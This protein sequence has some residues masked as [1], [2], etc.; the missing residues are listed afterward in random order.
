M[1]K[2]G[3]GRRARERVCGCSARSV[4]LRERPCFPLRERPWMTG[5]DLVCCGMPIVTF[6]AIVTTV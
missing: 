3:M 1:K 5:F 4:P 6:L 2:R